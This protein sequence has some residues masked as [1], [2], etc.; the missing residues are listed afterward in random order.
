MDY[1]EL[2]SRNTSVTCNNT[3]V[4][5][6]PVN[7]GRKVLVIRNSSTNG[8]VHTIHMGAQVA[9]AG[10][11]IILTA[12]QSLTDA[13]NAGYQC[14]QGEVQAIADKAGPGGVLSVFE[15]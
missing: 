3:S 5:L 15:R 12:G 13:N 8:A 14:W 1:N 7:P 4:Q 11:G 10:A 9:V 2:Q 6:L